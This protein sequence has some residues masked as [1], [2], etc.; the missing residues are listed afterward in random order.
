MNTC[1]TN[2]SSSHRLVKLRCLSLPA[3]L[4]VDTK[5]LAAICTR[6]TRLES[7]GHLRSSTATAVDFGRLKQLRNFGSGMF[8]HTMFT[9]CAAVTTVSLCGLSQLTTVGDGFLAGCV[10]LASVDLSGLSQLTIVGDRFLGSCTLLTTV[11]LSS[12]SQLTTVGYRFLSGCTSL[13]TVNLSG[14]SKLTTVGANFLCDCWSL[15]TVDLSVLSQLSW[16][17]EEFM[18]GCV[19]AVGVSEALRR[20]LASHNLEG[21]QK[22]SGGVE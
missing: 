8:T 22:G 2:P 4:D 18:F 19:K 9:R 20:R 16:I 1:D 14:L 17:G 11:D 12:L 21:G 10:E 5:S 3:A 7:V 6:L 13:T 15:T